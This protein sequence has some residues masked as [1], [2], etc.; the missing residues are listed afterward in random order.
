[1]EE[2]D[3]IHQLLHVHIIGSDHNGADGLFLSAVLGVRSAIATPAPG[4]GAGAVEN[5]GLPGF[6]DMDRRDDVGDRL[7]IDPAG[8]SDRHV[9][10]GA[11]KRHR[12]PPA[13]R[14]SLVC[15]GGRRK[16]C[17]R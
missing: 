7:Q 8:D 2:S 5:E 1:L 16:S 10:L 15:A 13:M 17:P 12:P 14:G 9:G 3:A 6:A 4:P 11:A